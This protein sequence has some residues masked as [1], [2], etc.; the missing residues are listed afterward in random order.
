MHKQLESPTHGWKEAGKNFKPITTTNTHEA[1]SS[2]RPAGAYLP[3]YKPTRDHPL[4]FWILF[5]GTTN[6]GHY[7]VIMRDSRYER[8]ANHKEAAWRT[9]DT[10][11]NE[12]RNQRTIAT[13]KRHEQLWNN[14][15]KY[16]KSEDDI[17]QSGN[18]NNCLPNTIVKII[19]CIMHTE[20][21]TKRDKQRKDMNNRKL[22]MTLRKGT[23]QE[24]FDQEA[25]SFMRQTIENREIN[26]QHTVFDKMHMKFNR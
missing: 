23:T 19:K 24:Q 14:N 16:I 10:I 5:S 20:G 15:M 8:R 12:E 7:N 2:T 1:W 4:I 13:F 17:E 6:A 22:T 18:S 25:R 11:N 21:L 3:T 9:L 26:D